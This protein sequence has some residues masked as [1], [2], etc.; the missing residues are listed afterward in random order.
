MHNELYIKDWLL[1]IDECIKNNLSKICSINSSKY[2]NIVIFCVAYGLNFNLNEVKEILLDNVMYFYVNIM[3]KDRIIN[4][5]FTYIFLIY[6]TKRKYPNTIDEFLNRNPQSLIKVL[7]GM[8]NI[9]D[10]IKS[11]IN[12]SYSINTYG[13]ILA[14][15]NN[16]IRQVKQD[17]HTIDNFP[18]QVAM[19]RF[20]DLFEAIKYNGIPPYPKFPS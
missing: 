4:L 1:S 5:D 15:V 9:S 16:L 10:T 6:A 14:G 12:T 3:K 17:Y 13:S 18:E 11:F 2:D 8:Q 7:N 20:Q 19:E